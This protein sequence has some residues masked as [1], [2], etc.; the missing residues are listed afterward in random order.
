MIDHR[1]ASGNMMAEDRALR[2]DLRVGRSDA[3]VRRIAE[4]A[5]WFAEWVN[6]NGPV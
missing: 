6:G 4:I 5:K 3:G 1:S 2:P